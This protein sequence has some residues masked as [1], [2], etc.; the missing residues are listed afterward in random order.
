MQQYSLY[1]TLGCHLCEQ[2]QALLAPWQQGGHLHLILIDIA[3]SPAL[4]ERF[5]VHIPVLQAHTS[6]QCLY[7]PFTAEGLSAFIQREA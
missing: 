2:A 6:G 1:G 4:V 5:G 3:D 7:W